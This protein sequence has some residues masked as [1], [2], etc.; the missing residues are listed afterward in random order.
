MFGPGFQP[1]VV[2][3]LQDSIFIVIPSVVEGSI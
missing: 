2:R 1:S 3:T